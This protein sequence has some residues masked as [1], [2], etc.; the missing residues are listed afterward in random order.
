[1]IKTDIKAAI[2]SI[3][4]ELLIGQVVNTNAAWMGNEMNNAGFS[5]QRVTSIADNKNDIF[6]ALDHALADNHITLAEYFKTPLI[7]NESVL[8]NV[9]YFFASRG[10]T[11]TEENKLQ[12]MVPENCTVIGNEVGTAPGMVFEIDDKIIVSMPGVPAEMKVLMRKY[13]IPILKEKYKTQAIYHKTVLT[14]G[15]G[16]SDMANL[17]KDWEKELPEHISLAYLPSYGSLRLRLSGVGSNNDTLKNEVD[18]EIKKLEDIIHHYIF[19]YDNE[20]L[21]EIIGKLLSSKQM[22]VST[23]ESYTGGNIAGAITRIPGASQ[24]FKGTIV[25]YDNKVKEEVLKVNPNDITNHG[26]VSQTVAE[27]MA[28]NVRTLLKTDFG[29]ATTG[30]AGPSGGSK[31]KPVGLVWIAIATPNG[32]FSQRFLLG[33]NRNK[34][35]LQSIQIAL[36]LLRVHLKKL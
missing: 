10:R 12:A 14:H 9:E 33:N 7:F 36:N 18:A 34:T 8:K 5:V 27:Q 30:I 4:D 15:I 22:T 23:A 13:V 31:E 25:A 3:G 32:V 16:E 11:F 17:I 28:T 35:V 24:Y 29:I 20:T 21:E 1:M 19:G 6:K 2:I 26:A